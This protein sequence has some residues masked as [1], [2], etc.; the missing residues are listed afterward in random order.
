MLETKKSFFRTP[1][2]KKPMSPIKE[3]QS[4]LTPQKGTWPEEV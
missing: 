3:E 4:L 2:K 1:P